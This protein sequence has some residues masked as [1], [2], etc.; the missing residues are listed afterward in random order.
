MAIGHYPS[1]CFFEGTTVSVGRGTNKQFQ[2]IG[3]PNYQGASFNFTPKPMPGARYPKNENKLCNGIDLSKVRP[4]SK[5]LDL[6]YLLD[7]YQNLSA[8]EV[9]FFNDDNFFNLLA[10]TDK[11]KA[12]IIAGTREEEIRA[13][14]EAGLLDFKMMRKKYLIYQ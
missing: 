2:V 12:Q 3:H 13:G 14:W 4:L 9:T 1:L 7:F 6:S 8:Q 10:G 5:R 11:L